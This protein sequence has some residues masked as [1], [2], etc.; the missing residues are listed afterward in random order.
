MDHLQAEQLI[1]QMKR[2]ADAQEGMLA[3]AAEA[4]VERLEM[5][6]QL[7]AQMKAGFMA[8]EEKK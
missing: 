3:I 2:I 6:K 8:R 7:K 4:R 1:A 5:S